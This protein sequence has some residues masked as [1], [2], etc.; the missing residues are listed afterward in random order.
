MRSG[1]GWTS[2]RFFNMQNVGIVTGAGSGVGRAVA[3]RLA[4]DG[5][6]VAVLA[7]RRDSLEG[8][9]RAAPEP[10]RPRIHPF[11]C[12]VADA[13]AVASVVSDVVKRFGGVHALVNSAGTNIPRR[14][15]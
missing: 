15:L 11:P 3:L 4:Q 8:M 12:D 13:A 2:R 9:V 14:N 7:R 5:W 1:A 6:V 10:S